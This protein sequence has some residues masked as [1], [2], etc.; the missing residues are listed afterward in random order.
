M[1]SFAFLPLA[2]YN[3]D[4]EV[5]HPLF[6]LM[7]IG[8][9][10][11]GLI[12]TRFQEKVDMKIGTLGYFIPLIFLGPIYLGGF[13][14]RSVIPEDP[15]TFKWEIGMHIVIFSLLLQYFASIYADPTM[16]E[17]KSRKLKKRHE[18]IGNIIG[19]REVLK[20]MAK[21]VGHSLVVISIIITSIFLVIVITILILFS[22]L[23]LFYP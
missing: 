23:Y 21:E 8:L 11:L 15:I 2:S 14:Q 9:S 12:L 7:I 13:E 10:F 22:I 19:Y 20:Q 18:N 5:F 16:S 3:G 1:I 4:H 6:I 17:I